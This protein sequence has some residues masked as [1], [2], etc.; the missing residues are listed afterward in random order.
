MGPKSMLICTAGG[1]VLRILLLL[2][3]SLD[4]TILARAVS[5]PNRYPLAAIDASYLI[6]RIQ[7]SPVGGSGTRVGSSGLMKPRVSEALRGISEQC[8]SPENYGSLRAGD[9]PK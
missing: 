3:D 4:S 2:S 5:Y 8:R 1:D 6:S 9:V 7:P